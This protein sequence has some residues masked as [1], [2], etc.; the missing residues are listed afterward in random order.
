MN[1]FLMLLVAVVL[2]A[3]G[4]ETISVPVKVRSPGLTFIHLNDTYRID[5]VEDG[6]KGG[7]AR[8]ATVVRE[9]QKFGRDVRILHAGDFLF[10]SLE[11]QLWRGEQMIDGLNFLDDL[12]PLYLV[13][14]NHEFDP[15]T[16][17]HLVE[18]LR[19]SSFDWI[20]DN[21]SFH[22]GDPAVD[23]LLKSAFTTE[24]KD[25]KIGVFGLMLHPDDGG[26][27]RDY[28]SVN[29]DYVGV[30]KRMIESFE[31]AGV[32]MIIGIT[33]LHM[34]TDKEIAMLRAEHPLLT[35][36][37][38]G[39]E[40]EPEFSPMRDDSAAVMKGASNARAIWRI[41]VDFH[42]DSPPTIRSNVIPLD[43]RVKQ[44]TDFLALERKWRRRLLKVYPFLD[45]R[46]GKAAMPL[47]GR[48]MAIRN[49]ETGLGNFVVDQ[50]RTAFG[51]EPADL[52]FINSGT[53]R[54]DDFVQGDV[55]FEDIGRIFGF[56]SYL[57]YLEMTGA[58][59]QQ[60]LE[61]GYRG[62]G[63]SQGYFPQVSGFRVCVDRRLP[64]FDRIVSLQLPADEGWVE[65]DAE[66]TYDVVVPDYLFGGGDGYRFPAHL[67]ASKRG[68]E[69]KYL[70]LDA[71]LRAQA[72]GEGIG[73][74][75]DPD[76]PR[77]VAL[78]ASRPEC[79]P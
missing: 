18:A 47:D 24:Y 43:R 57:R 53:L 59:F 31:A 27:D 19:N 50:M 29:G 67:V 79:W 16:P 22:T 78:G 37:V 46:V 20:G 26:N 30:A 48:E 15:R 32:D 13:P 74:A 69:L 40:H 73:E 76:N 36:I 42:D 34:W 12:A 52:A 2:V 41:D 54:L 63:P 44:D 56:S 17:D 45:A 35:F 23:G 38:G 66:A 4:S 7:Y 6:T 28:L 58:E 75:V 25:W 68:S 39:H 11:S 8:V 10:P 70:V 55:H 62:E 14:G 5:A 1:K 21:F 64:E 60:V 77:Y 3:C 61:A 33:H 49:Q 9:L 51:R 65:I 71:V 72:E